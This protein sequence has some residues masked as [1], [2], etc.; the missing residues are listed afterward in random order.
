[1]C[2]GI[3]S[4]AG[5]IAAAVLSGAAAIPAFAFAGVG[6]ILGALIAYCACRMSAGRLPKINPPGN[7]ETGQTS[8]IGIVND[9]GRSFAL[10]PFGDGD[11][12]FNIR[13]VPRGFLT[14]QASGDAACIRTKDLING[15]EYLHCEITSNVTLYG[16]AGAVTGAAAAAPAGVALGTGAGL[17]VAAGCL[18]LGIFAPLCFLAAILV[19]LIVSSLVTGG[20]ALAGAAIGSAA[21]LAA[22]ELADQVG[23]AGADVVE[24]GDAVVFTGD[25]VTDADHGWNE[26][27][28]IR[29]AMIID[30]G[31]ELC[32]R[33]GKVAGAVGT[34]MM[35]P[36]RRAAG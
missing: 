4:L 24:C 5:A 1:M 17:A 29:A 30:R 22:D 12:L 3:G 18:A 33:V 14:P 11:Y 16:C 7:P 36:P 10:F 32:E 8:V 2:A 9:I 15:P 31:F 27:H 35:A 21:G 13:C 26:I 23:E 28:D 20:G 19:A 25:W 34:G 6:A